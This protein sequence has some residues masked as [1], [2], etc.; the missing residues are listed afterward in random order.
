MFGWESSNPGGILVYW[1]SCQKQIFN[2][3]EI[4]LLKINGFKSEAEEWREKIFTY[5]NS[6]VGR[7]GA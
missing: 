3:E 2:C 4:K 1:E 7:K 5:N 6:Y